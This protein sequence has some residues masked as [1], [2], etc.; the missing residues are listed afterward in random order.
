MTEKIEQKEAHSERNQRFIKV[1]KEQ[2]GIIT[3]LTITGNTISNNSDN[4]GEG[5]SVSFT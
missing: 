5:E 4:L 3:E 1:L 2:D